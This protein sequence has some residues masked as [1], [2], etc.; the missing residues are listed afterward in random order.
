MCYTAK[1]LIEKALK[2]A[3]HYGVKEDIIR[4]EEE[5]RNFKD[6]EKA[7]GFGHPEV[8]IYTNEAPYHP[9][10]S[11]WGL[12]PHWIKD[13]NQAKTI[14]NK[15]LN[16][17]GESL[18]QKP[19][20]RD[21]VRHHR[22]LIPIAGFY[23]YHHQGKSTIPYYIERRDQEPI[24]LAGLWSEWHSK[25]Q[26][27]TLNTCS[28]VTTKAN[29]LMAKIHNNPKLSEA[30]MPLILKDGAEDNWLRLRTEQQLKLFLE[31]YP[32]EELRA[33]P[34]KKNIQPRIPGL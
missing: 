3:R 24:M 2:R 18:F 25:E 7:S 22:C 5:L 23:E 29:P 9:I 21:A 6:H 26:N 27:R 13:E 4:Y 12:I 30:R 16:A 28:I 8:I 19:S 31:P 20:F 34:E 32:Q 15:T 1:Y 14:W 33:K 11:V 10:L 17:R